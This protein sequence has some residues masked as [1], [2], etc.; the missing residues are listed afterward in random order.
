MPKTWYCVPPEHGHL[1][2]KTCT[3]LFP[4]VASFCNNFMR[5]KT[6]LINPKVLDKY[7]VPYNKMVQKEREIIVV[8]PYAYHSGFNHGFNIAES[9]NF[10][11][12]R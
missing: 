8:F 10:A 9:T 11:L 4:H 2:E 6:C 7:G 12:E 1:L 3:E 5:H